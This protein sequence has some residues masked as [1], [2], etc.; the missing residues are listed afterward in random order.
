MVTP[1]FVAAPAR[2]PWTTCPAR[3]ASVTFEDLC[4]RQYV[5]TPAG[6]VRG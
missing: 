1:L 3:A 6:N 5:I 2:S 4:L